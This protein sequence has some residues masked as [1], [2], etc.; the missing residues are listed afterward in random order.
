MV[1]WN[2]HNFRGSGNQLGV[3]VNLSTDTISSSVLYNRRWM[4]G[5]PLS[6][7]FDFTVGWS[8]RKAAMNNTAPFW[9]GD[10]AS[11]FPDGFAS[12]EEYINANR[13]PSAEFLMDFQQVNLSLGFSTGY[14]WTFPVGLFSL[15]GGLRVGMIHT[16]YDNGRPFDP[17]LR[18]GN[19][20][21]VPMNSVW[22][23]LALDRRDIAFDPTSGYY[24][25]SRFSINGILPKEREYY[26]R[27]ETNAQYFI[28]LFNIPVSD[29]WSFRMTLGLYSGLSFIFAQPGRDLKIEDANRLA[30]DGMFTARGWGGAFRE[31]GHAMW[32]N[33]VE[34]R[35]PLVPNLLAW[36]FFFDAAGV[37]G[38]SEGQQQFTYFDNFDITNMRF[39]F[40]G[41]LRFTIPQLPF[42]LSL[43]KRFRVTDGQVQW[44]KG[45]LFATDDPNSGLDPVLSISV[46]F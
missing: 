40:G 5:L 37:A 22:T 3:D 20:I 26:I 39:S 38:T 35:T 33:W 30:I 43:A 36:D 34:L 7:G 12:R 17:A 15:G 21:W 4:F 42:R 24:L 9:N 31:K 32:N 25:F 6:G 29:D 45:A 23:S 27:N 2:D 13:Q 46:S 19:N 44:Q 14:R 10:E 1:M 18:E 41:G 16:M 11:A 28:P 8:K